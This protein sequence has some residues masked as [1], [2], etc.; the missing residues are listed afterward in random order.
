[1]S[2]QTI[3]AP[4]TVTVGSPVTIEVEVCPETDSL[5]PAGRVYL[6]IDG[7]R[8]TNVTG[9]HLRDFCI[10]QSAGQYSVGEQFEVP[11]FADLPED[12]SGGAVTFTEPGTYTL[13]TPTDSKTITV[14]EAPFEQSAVSVTC[15]G[16]LPA[17]ITVGDEIE[18][19]AEV[20]NNNDSQAGVVVGFAVGGT[21]TT[22]IVNVSAND[23]EVVSDTFEA[24]ST[25]DISPTVSKDQVSEGGVAGVPHDP[26]T[27]TF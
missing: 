23:S 2:T 17:E 25:G 15:S 1:M 13:S 9:L 24:A 22:K 27:P 26:G 11:P 12:G 8:V 6:D 20:V 19:A 5:A 3:Q 18:I 10:D 16:S 4:D 7:Y 21:S 14:E